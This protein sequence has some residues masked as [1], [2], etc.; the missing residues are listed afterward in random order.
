MN[1]GC[2]KAQHIWHVYRSS[3]FHDLLPQL[4]LNCCP[5]WFD[6]NHNLPEFSYTVAI[7]PR[8]HS[9]Y[10]IFWKKHARTMLFLP[11]TSVKGWRMVELLH[12]VLYVNHYLPEFWN[13]VE[14]FPLT[15]APTVNKIG[16]FNVWAIFWTSK[17]SFKWCRMDELQ[18]WILIFRCSCPSHSLF[19]FFCRVKCSRTNFV[20]YLPSIWVWWF[21]MDWTFN[22]IL[23]T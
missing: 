22:M 13:P 8:I 20:P 19:L 7:F 17:W 6:S 2:S 15:L 1:K 11:F 5:R 18:Q 12:M 23:S 14:A 4:K 10:V 21:F 16:L 9:S 3:I